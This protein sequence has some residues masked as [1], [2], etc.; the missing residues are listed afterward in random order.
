[1]ETV[2]FSRLHLQDKA[3]V[4][5]LGAGGGRH[6]LRASE[7]GYMS[8]ALDRCSDGLV[9]MNNWIEHAG[10]GSSIEVYSVVGDANELPFPDAIFDAV[11]CSEVLEHVVEPI[12]IVSEIYRVLKLGGTVAITVP[13]TYPEVVCWLISK[14][15]HS[16]KG[17]HIRIFRRGTLV[18]LCESVGLRYCSFSYTHALH[19]PYWWLKCV[20][21]V[22]KSGNRIVDLYEKLLIKQMSDREGLLNRLDRSLGRLFGKSMVVYA[23]KR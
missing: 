6:A 8:F 11:V 5:D 14:E 2:E 15:Y 7:V 16:A 19:T 23:K 18:D 22:N 13:R 1:M 17:G 9:S 20:I 12:G 3:K 21:G 10:V 4:L